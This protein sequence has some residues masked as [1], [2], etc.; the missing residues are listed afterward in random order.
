MH[1]VAI[2]CDPNAEEAKKAIIKYLTQKG[3]AVTDMGSEDPIYANVAIKV[4]T[5]VAGGKYD[6]GILICGTGIGVSIVANKV[7][8]AYAALL[9]DVYSAERARKSNDANI[10]CFGAFTLGIK[11]MEKLAEVFLTSEFEKGCASQP[12]VDRIHEYEAAQQ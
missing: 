3:Y 12:K 10:A 6:R 8:G 5:A 9:T 1:T 11:H 7:K 4:A 2:G